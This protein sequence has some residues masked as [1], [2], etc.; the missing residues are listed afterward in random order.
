M[1]SK[2]CS[3]ELVEQPAPVVYT[4]GFIDPA[5]PVQRVVEFP[6]QIFVTSKKYSAVDNLLTLV[7]NAHG[8]LDQW[9]RFEKVN[10]HMMVSGA[11]WNMKGQ[12]GVLSSSHIE[13]ELHEQRGR[14]LDFEN[15]SGRETYFSPDR[16]A[17]LDRGHIIQE[18]VNPRESFIHHHLETAWTRLQ[19]VYFG[20]YAMW[21]Y[22][23]IPFSFTLPG[24]KTLELTP[25]NEAGDTWRRLQV[26]FPDD[27]AYHSR[28]QVFYFGE[29]GRLKRMDYDVEISGNTTVAQYVSNYREVQG[30]RLPTRRLVFQRDETGRYIPQPLIVSIELVDINFR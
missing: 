17:I 25:W 13:L 2:H 29:D 4:T 3:G 27:W 20:T 24:V 12:E 14:Y 6:Q 9:A 22:L 8:G 1:L 30:I 10:V 7:V 18:L 5:E 26:R 28:E 15:T 23:T 19:L 21:E 11:L 16:V